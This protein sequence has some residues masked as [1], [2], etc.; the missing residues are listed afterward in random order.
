MGLQTQKRGCYTLKT[1]S[2]YLYTWCPD[3]T[4]NKAQAGKNVIKN[5]CTAIP[6][7]QGEDWVCTYVYQNAIIDGIL[8][9]LAYVACD[10]VK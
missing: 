4:V 5:Y 1:H 9:R 6:Y 10:Y 7:S 3:K 8:K 2:D